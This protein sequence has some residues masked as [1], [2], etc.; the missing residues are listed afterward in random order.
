METQSYHHQ[1][2]H[3]SAHDEINLSLSLRSRITHHDS[4]IRPTCALLFRDT[5]AS[6]RDQFTK[7]RFVIWFERA[8]NSSL[9]RAVDAGELEDAVLA[10]A[11]QRGR[12]ATIPS[13]VLKK[14][15]GFG[16]SSLGNFCSTADPL[17]LHMAADVARRERRELREG[18]VTNLAARDRVSWCVPGSELLDCSMNSCRRCTRR[19][20]G[21]QRLA[22]G[23]THRRFMKY[24]F[25]YKV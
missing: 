3:S 5:G 1:H 21:R 18:G 20:K 9:F 12:D 25:P 14:G 8:M 17:I 11:E 7:D 6:S 19:D 2:R 10:K 24:C 23:D 22:C 4:P 13:F 15:L 16:P